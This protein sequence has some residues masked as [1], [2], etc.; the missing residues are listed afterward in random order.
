MAIAKAASAKKALDIVII[1]M[2]KMA[3]VADYFII[4]SGTSTTQ[5][6]AI[7]D[8]IIKELKDKGE[9]PWHVEG[10]RESVWILVD[11]GDCVAHVFLDE[12][13]RY[14]DLER[15]WGDAPQEKFRE[16][17]VKRAIR[18]VRAAHKKR[19]KNRKK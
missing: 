1:N 9:R 17:I 16:K 6:R 11:Y 2:R 12:K 13:R 14:Y 10:E 3:S 5:V 4:T 19:N 8:S 7:S 15:L 18:R